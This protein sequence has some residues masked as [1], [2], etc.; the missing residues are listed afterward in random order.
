MNLV[1]ENSP[2][3]RL[4]VFPLLMVAG[5]VLSVAMLRPDLAYK[6]AYCPLRDTTG[7]PCLTCG[8]THSIV[9]LMQGHWIEA[10]AANP[11][12]AVGTVLF[13]LWSGYAVVATI[14]PAIRRSL[15]LLAYEK[16]AARIAATLLILATWA[17]EFKQFCG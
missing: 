5:A 13:V 2:W 10:M 1:S 12:V 8:G 9:A 3:P 17:W 16:R 15:K 6:W 14:Y 11:L 7:I 4:L